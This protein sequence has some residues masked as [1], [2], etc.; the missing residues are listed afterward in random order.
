MKD[1][2][3]FKSDKIQFYADENVV[4]PECLLKESGCEIPNLNQID[5]CNPTNVII[6]L[7]V[8]LELICD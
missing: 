5:S 4:V 3:S 8:L 6:E 1:R 7:C 2:R